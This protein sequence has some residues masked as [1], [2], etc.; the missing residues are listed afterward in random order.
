MVTAL[1]I[2]EHI[3]NID[4]FLMEASSLVKPGGM[5]FISSISKNL[6][7]YLLTIVAAEKLMR[8][9]PSGTHDYEKY[10]DSETVVTKMKN[11]NFN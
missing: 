10:I 2:I 8:I 4:L 3:D 6:L 7:S 1:E 9:V 11:L 5:L